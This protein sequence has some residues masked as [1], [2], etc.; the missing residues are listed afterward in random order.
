MNGD[1]SSY[2]RQRIGL[3]IAG[4][5]S[6]ASVPS[7]FLP[8]PEGEVG[9]PLGVLVVDA[10]LGAVGVL[11]VAIA[12]RTGNRAALRA[13]AGAIIVITITAMPAFFVDVPAGLKLLVGLSVLIT[14]TAVVLMFSP[15]GRAATVL[16]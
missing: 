8:T 7:A 4:L 3:A 14:I 13:A 5:Y 15:T 9:P 12:W 11:A 16:E 10:V 6:L 2:T 1:A